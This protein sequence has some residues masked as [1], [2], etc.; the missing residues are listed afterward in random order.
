MVRPV[1]NSWSKYSKKL[2]KPQMLEHNCFDIVPVVFTYKLLIKLFLFTSSRR[3]RSTVLHLHAGDE[4]VSFHCF[5][6]LNHIPR[7]ISGLSED[8]MQAFKPGPHPSSKAVP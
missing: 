6:S 4:I 2:S 5:I 3:L 1:D 7:R 8:R